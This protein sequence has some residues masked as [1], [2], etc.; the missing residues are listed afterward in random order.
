[1]WR[2]LRELN[3]Y[4]RIDSPASSPLRPRHHMVMPAGFEP[5]LSDRKSDVLTPRRRH[6]ILFFERIIQ[7]EIPAVVALEVTISIL[8]KKTCSSF[9]FLFYHRSFSL[10]WKNPCELLFLICENGYKELSVFGKLQIHNTVL[11]CFA[12]SCVPCVFV[13]L[14]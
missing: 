11:C 10:S 1:M 8:S 4:L 6:H 9:V 7:D 12:V 3:P 14:S 2:C 13:A 5:A